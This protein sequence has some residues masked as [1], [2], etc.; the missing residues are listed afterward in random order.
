M[1][2][3]SGCGEPAHFPSHMYGV[4]RTPT[5]TTVNQLDDVR[6]SEVA[7][8]IGGK[9]DNSES[10]RSAQSSD[11]LFTKHT[12]DVLTSAIEYDLVHS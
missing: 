3:A 5:A 6:F 7:P 1:V 12:P 11:L 9:N 10:C 2:V 4:I 8:F